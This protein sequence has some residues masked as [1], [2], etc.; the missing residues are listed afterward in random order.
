MYLVAIAWI[1][2]ALMMALAEA[3]HPSGT[4]L[5]AFITFLFYGVGPVALVLYLLGTPMR[6]R[7]RKA[8]DLAERAALAEAADATAPSVAQPD[9][10]GHAPAA[11]LAPERKEP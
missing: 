3:N 2:V 10:R 9:Q 5:G 6:W 4:L 8:A 1:Y 7:A 11:P